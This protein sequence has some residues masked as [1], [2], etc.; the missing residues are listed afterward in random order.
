ML[1]EGEDFAATFA[2]FHGPRG[3]VPL[4]RTVATVTTASISSLDDR[5]RRGASSALSSRPPAPCSA[6]ASISLSG[7]GFLVCHAV[8]GRCS[9]PNLPRTLYVSPFCRH[10]SVLSHSLCCAAWREGTVPSRQAAAAEP[11]ARQGEGTVI[12]VT[13]NS[14]TAA[15]TGAG[16]G[17]GQVPA[18]GPGAAAGRSAGV[19][20]EGSVQVPRVDRQDARGGGSAQTYPPTAPTGESC[21][22]LCHVEPFSCEYLIKCNEVRVLQKMFCHRVACKGS[23]KVEL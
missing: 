19:Q 14:V 12:S 13:A 3:V 22:H 11:K 15:H 23:E 4:Q 2:L 1:E 7:F 18:A 8:Q 10:R 21:S 6:A 16:R 20:R 5:L 9:C 17:T